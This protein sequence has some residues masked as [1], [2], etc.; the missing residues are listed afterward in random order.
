M[1]DPA[2]MAPS[3]ASR[4]RARAAA[5]LRSDRA[6][7]LLLVGLAALLRLP[8]VVD[9]GIFDADQG[10]DMLVIYNLVEHGRFPLLGPETISIANSHLHHGAFYWYLFAPAA[11]LS[12][13]DP[14]AVMVETALIG[15]AAVAATWWAARLMGGPVVAAVAGLLFA[16]SPAAVEQSIFLWNPNPV[17]LFA[18]LALGGA[19]RGHQTG[20][21]RWYALAMG[22]AVAVYELHL[23]GA[24]FVVGIGFLI[25]YDLV[26]ALGRNRER[27]PGL[28][29][30]IA[31]GLVL[32]ALL[33]LP[34]IVNELQT[35]FD[36]TQKLIQFVL[37]G[38]SVP[39][40]GG[41]DPA[42]AFVFII[43]RIVSWPF[44]GLVI[45]APLAAVL[46]VTVW[47]ILVAWWLRASRGEDGVAMAWLLA[48]VA[49]S[50]VT[51][52]VLAPWLRFVVPG[53]PVDHYHAFLNPVVIIAVSF[54]GVAF[55]R[56]VDAIGLS[57][58]P[59]RS[60][61]ASRVAR[62][63]MAIAL[64]AE[65]VVAGARQPGPSLVAT[66]PVAKAVG[67]EIVDLAAGRSMALAGLPSLPEKSPDSIGYPIIYLG[68][69]VIDDRTAAQLLVV[70][71][72]DRFFPVA[73]VAHCGGP[74]E[75][76]DAT[77]LLH[78]DGLEPT[79][80]GRFSESD[81]LKI[82]VYSIGPRR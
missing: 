27:L 18:A 49:F 58:E 21:G 77:F 9:R 3:R 7:L 69:D 72:D 17:P 82:S 64:V 52:P 71:C 53:F 39:T 16:V 29:R 13:G 15:I 75:D 22:S 41:L 30:G 43:V 20:R 48:I 44:V 37:H 61:N 46:V 45:D 40:T 23:L 55:A 28:A 51:L 12:G 70:N 33:F 5:L 80:L 63:F 26:R 67:Q 47:L 14:G 8:G 31:G 50:A 6:V 68:G 73:L 66:W 34:L 2:W 62:A 65:L 32:T 76:E 4:A 79:L 57:R 74:A 42:S 59:A 81:D 19:W 60:A 24:T 54:A 35:N 10:R 25:A 1:L 38:G 78:E 36:E 56:G 11:W